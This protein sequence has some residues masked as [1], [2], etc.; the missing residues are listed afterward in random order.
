MAVVAVEGVVTLPPVQTCKLPLE[1]VQTVVEAVV[2]QMRGEE[3]AGEAAA[4]EVRKPLQPQLAVQALVV[5][6]QAVQAQAPL[7]FPKPLLEL[8]LLRL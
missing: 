2:L 1:E 4:A 3:E 8:H 7:P 6:V 5:H